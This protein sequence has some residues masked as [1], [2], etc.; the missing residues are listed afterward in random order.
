MF[1]Y[2]LAWP[3]QYSPKTGGKYNILKDDY[4]NELC[5]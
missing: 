3:P 1:S 5:K 4:N 2:L